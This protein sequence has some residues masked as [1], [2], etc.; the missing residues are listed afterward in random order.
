MD[1]EGAH[2]G[3]GAVVGCARGEPGG[4][5]GGQSSGA[6]DEEV[7]ARGLDVAAAE[8]AAAVEGA[9]DDPVVEAEG[10]EAVAAGEVEPGLGVAVA[11]LLG[12]ANL[13]VA[14]GAVFVGDAGGMVMVIVVV[15]EG[16]CLG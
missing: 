1:A 5:A 15:L 11:V 16:G 9:V 2:V 14:D 12:R 8:G 7:A 6:R 10:A 13:F 4:L 3:D